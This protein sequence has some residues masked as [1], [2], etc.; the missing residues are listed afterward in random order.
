MKTGIYKITNTNTNKVYIG[1]A[2]NI[3]LRWKEH[4]NDLKKG[5]HHS[6]KLQRSFNKHGVNS[7]KFEIIEQCDRKDLIKHEQAYIDL[8][9][10]YSEG[11]NSSPTAGSRLGSGQSEETK[12]KI[13]DSLKGRPSPNKGV[14]A[15]QATRDKLSKARKGKKL[16]STHIYNISQ[17]KI[18]DK[19]PFFGKKVKEEHKICKKINQFTKG[20][21]F[22]KEWK[23]V[24]ECA[25]ALNTQI[26]FISAVLTGKRPSH[27]GFVFKYV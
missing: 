1:S 2:V 5:L 16:S 11:Y 8:L 9:K 10:A 19:N 21:E 23:S 27:L 26:K 4:L 18:G 12:K 13:S 17:A 15:S 25:N 6:I 14:V 7:F 3:E 20:N 24:T 22:I